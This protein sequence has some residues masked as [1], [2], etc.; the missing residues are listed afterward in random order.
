[1]DGFDFSDL[2]PEDDAPP[3]RSSYVRSA[4]DIEIDWA[5]V[6]AS[7]KYLNSVSEVE[8]ML[9]SWPM[10][11]LETAAT[12][13][14]S[15]NPSEEWWGRMMPWVAWKPVFGYL[16]FNTFSAIAGK[17]V[18]KT[19][20]ILKDSQFSRE[21]YLLMQGKGVLTCAVDPHAME[22]DGRTSKKVYT[23]TADVAKQRF[24]EIDRDLY[25][26]SQVFNLSF[27]DKKTQKITDYIKTTERV[28]SKRF[29]YVPD[30]ADHCAAPGLF[31]KKIHEGG[32]GYNSVF[33]AYWQTCKDAAAKSRK[34]NRFFWALLHRPPM[35][36]P[37]DCP[38]ILPIGPWAGS[39]SSGNAFLASLCKEA[40]FV[41]C[42]R[43]TNA[44]MFV[45]AIKTIV[46][47]TCST[48]LVIG[49]KLPA[50]TMQWAEN[51]KPA[52]WV[53]LG[54]FQVPPVAKKAG[55]TFESV[56][57]SDMMHHCNVFV[58]P[59]SSHYKDKIAKGVVLIPLTD[60]FNAEKIIKNWGKTKDCAAYVT[61]GPTPYLWLINEKTS[62]VP[63]TN[64]PSFY[65]QMK[66]VVKRLVW[67]RLQEF[68]GGHNGT[69]IYKLAAKP[70]AGGLMIGCSP[71][72]CNWALIRWTPTEEAVAKKN[73]GIA[74]D[75]E[76]V[77]E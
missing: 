6:D 68:S 50:N 38:T 54:K 11:A 31:P 73:K 44:H 58:C 57:Q 76:F 74:G 29:T 4:A 25:F 2:P 10:E 22:D 71:I 33:D 36:K 62:T 51:V 48:R 23:W 65:C 35:P 17:V 7:T 69:Y 66:E 63:A 56:E 28:F 26:K 16:T 13:W 1:M 49:G 9:D 70:T 55:H 21:D 27:S 46:D 14:G 39:T 40:S 47:P 61:L 59:T 32:S 8:D 64:L 42:L 5:D 43:L 45:S 53:G 75:A 34:Q 72:M 12:F 52:T 3:F 41:D 15:E 24:V 67:R 77:W 20:A 60:D 30:R 18:N 19:M 37:V